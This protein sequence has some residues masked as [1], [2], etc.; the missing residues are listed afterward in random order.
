MLAISVITSAPAAMGDEP[1]YPQEYRIYFIGNSLTRGLSLAPNPAHNRL[2]RLFNNRGKGFHWGSQMGAGIN[3]DE[4]YAKIRYAT[5]QA[6]VLNYL[7]D[8]GET[9]INNGGD[10]FLDP[11]AFKY[12]LMR[13]Y[14]FAF[15]GY[16][17]TP[18]GTITTPTRTVHLRSGMALM[19]YPRTPYE[20]LQNPKDPISVNYFIF[21]P[22]PPGARSDLLVLP[23]AD[24]SLYDGL[25]RRILELF[26]ESYAE[27]GYQPGPDSPDV[28]FTDEEEYVR[29]GAFCPNPIS[30]FTPKRGAREPFVGHAQ[31]LFRLLLADFQHRMAHAPVKPGAAG[32]K[33]RHH[34]L[35]ADIAG[36]LRTRP[37]LF[38]S[39]RQIA[40]DA[41]YST[42]H[43]SRLFRQ[44]MGCSPK[45]YLLNC[46]MDQAKHLL[47][48]S[49]LNVNEIAERLGYSTPGFFSRQF[50]QV[51]GMSPGAYRKQAAGT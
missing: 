44:T 41:G 47:R 19:L 7:D 2:K 45:I 15:Q 48:E 49:A 43:F 5:G 39:I 8:W 29:T 1:I 33:A 16:E 14:H 38:N 12:A 42:D 20:V 22:C 23:H 51:E 25:T 28:M 9:Q 6:S 18:D 3:L 13:D 30:M 26:W 27:H 4:Q 50:K 46:R 35:M 36:R 32:I 21:T 31:N 17:R 10:A 24:F 11:D 37:E 34:D 40:A